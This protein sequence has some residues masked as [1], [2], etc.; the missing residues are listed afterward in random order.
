MADMRRT[1]PSFQ[2]GYHVAASVVDVASTTHWYRPT[3]AQYTS[4]RLGLATWRFE[5]LFFSNRPKSTTATNEHTHTGRLDVRSECIAGF[6]FLLRP[7]ASD[8]NGIRNYS[9]QRYRQPVV[10]RVVIRV[11]IHTAQLVGSRIVSEQGHVRQIKI[12]SSKAKH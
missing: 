7:I 11:H 12:R 2:F 8:G 10:M 1:V 3:Q 6:A 5:I 9:H 4:S